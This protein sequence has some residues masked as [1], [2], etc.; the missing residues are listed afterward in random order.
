MGKTRSEFPIASVLLVVVGALI[1]S[2]PAILSGRP[3]VYYDTWE[4][5]GWGRDVLAAIGDP[6]PAHG[7]FPVGRNLWASKAVSGP[8][9]IVDE[10]LFRLT[11]S[12]VGSRSAFYGVPLYGLRSLWLAAGVQAMLVSWTLWMVAR[13]FGWQQYRWAFFGTVLVLTVGT[14]LPF[15]TTF[16]MPDVFTGLAT[17][18]AGLL[19]F[20]PNQLPRSARWGL[21]VLITYAITVHTSN[22]GLIAAAIPIGAILISLT[23]SMRIAAW[24]TAPLC[25]TFLAGVVV[26]AIGAQGLK[27]VFGRP[28]Q[29]P[30]FLL[31][32]VIMDGPGR[33]YLREQCNRIAYIS[34]ELAN[35]QLTGTESFMWAL[36][37]TVP[38]S[39]RWDPDQRER[40]YAEQREIVLAAIRRDPFRQLAA[41]VRNAAKQ[42]TSFTLSN[43]M[44]AALVNVLHEGVR[45]ASV[46]A[47]IT[48]NVE[49]CSI[50]GG[51]LCNRFLS[52]RAWM[53]V[54]RWHYVVVAA[55]GLLLAFRLVPALLFLPRW[56]TLHPEQAFAFFTAL[57]VCANAVICGV[58]SGPYDRYQARIVWLVPLAAL[59]IE[60][61]SGFM[62][63]LRKPLTEN[64]PAVH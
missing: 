48:P 58:L 19:L 59:V 9:A 15:F 13:T 22:I 43:E 46:T 11:L 3:F 24:R 28:I 1:L 20:F 56:R 50:S 34:C 33:A 35:A 45:R 18:A 17:L 23:T 16:I 57:L 41:S 62:R 38:F 5:Y 39:P 27:M 55:A 53:L 29:N 4:F 14:S 36:D 21:P 47:S 64:A 51:E 61:R 60:A 54:H 2:V 63:G 12:T 42:L 10:T 37:G 8:P 7:P 31:A 30:P 6:W 44:N 40:F 32:R 49:P 26:L 52:K 25:A